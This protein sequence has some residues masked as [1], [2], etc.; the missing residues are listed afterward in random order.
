MAKRRRRQLID[1]RLNALDVTLLDVF[2]Q[3]EAMLRCARD[4]QRHVLKLRSGEGSL[5]GAQR[6]SIIEKMR[7]AASEALN[8]S[9]AILPLIRDVVHSVDH[10]E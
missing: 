10:L 5:A 1:D 2:A 8:E 4:I 6:A 3:A 9:K 7:S